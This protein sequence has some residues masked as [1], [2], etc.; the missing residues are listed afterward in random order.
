MQARDSADIRIVENPAPRLDEVRAWRILDEPAVV[1]GAS[2]SVIEHNPLD[3]ASVFRTPAGEIVVAD[4]LTNGWDRLLVYDSTGAFLR[5]IGRQGKG[6]C[7][8]GQVWWAEAYRRD[9][10]AVY[11]QSSDAVV[12]LGLDGGCA[13][14]VPPPRGEVTPEQ[15]RAGAFTAGAEA[16][17]PDGTI[18]SYP[19]GHV[20][21]P[22]S[23]G[24]AWFMHA[25]LRLSPDGMVMD[26]LG[27]FRIGETYW[28]GTQTR[29]LAY[30][31]W[32]HRAVDGFDL[33]FG[34]ARS[35]EFFR[36]DSTGTL[37]QIVRR[38]FTPVAITQEDRVSFVTAVFEAA[39]AVGREVAPGRP[40][41]PQTLEQR[42]ALFH[43]PS[44]KPAYSKLLVDPNGNVWIEEYRYFRP[45]AVSS[46][47]PP[48]WWS[49]FSREGEWL[50][51]VLVPGRLLVSRIYDDVIFGIW[52]DADGVGTVRGHR[53]IKPGRTRP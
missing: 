35:F 37:K 11:D 5:Y 3:P 6:P 29:S 2:D 46:D 13:R 10:V 36:Y 33:V 53:L 1:I 21:P 41:Q 42:I 9:S 17:Y 30:G 18:L 51:R 39:R 24:P 7:E 12:V 8:F 23:P 4:G 27:L 47:P 48:S 20:E 25:L 38:P 34:D 26:T 43:W 49:V 19:M 45:D 31:R 44:V 52:K 16:T 40:G 22:A 15:A 50:T 14:T 32:T 28:D